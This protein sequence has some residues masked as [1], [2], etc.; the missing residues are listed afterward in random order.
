MRIGQPVTLTADAYGTSVEYHGT[1][2]GMGV[3]TGGAFALLP[4]QNATG[5]WI[6]VVQRIPVRIALAPDELAA[7]PLRVGLSMEA[8]V[9]V[10]DTNGATLADAP[11]VAA[12]YTTAAFTHDTEDAEALVRQTIAANMGSASRSNGSATTAPAQVA[13]PAPAGTPRVAARAVR[14]KSSSSAPL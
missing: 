12:P 5:N 8:S 1:V 3:G 4:A 13:V 11:R 14:S 2:A 6:K 7:H 9:D 10:A